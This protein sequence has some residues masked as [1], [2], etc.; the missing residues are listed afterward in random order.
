MYILIGRSSDVVWSFQESNIV[1][2]SNVGPKFDQH[3]SYLSVQWHSPQ[4]SY[5]PPARMTSGQCGLTSRGHQGAHWE[6][7]FPV[8]ET[9][10]W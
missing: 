7:C 5:V 8:I 2:R 3:S 1:Q 10:T 4:R 9:P 6:S